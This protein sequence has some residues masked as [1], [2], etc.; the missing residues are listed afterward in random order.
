MV[1]ILLATYNSEPYIR[2]QL[3]SILNQSYKEWKLVVRDDLSN[4]RTVEIISEYISRY[5]DKISIL[6]NHGESKRAYLNFV[7]LLKNVES[8]YYMFCDHDDVWL[9][10]KI[11]LS[12]KRMKEVEKPDIPVVVHTD[13]RVVNEGLDTICDSF[14]RYSRL[15]P[16]HVEFKELAVCNSVNGCT[17]A[18]NKKARDLSLTHV[19]HA[20][21]HDKLV[22]RTVAANGGIISAIKAPTVLYR[23]HLDNVVGAHLRNKSFYKSKLKHLRHTIKRNIESWRLSS[24]IQY[25]SF[26][27]FIVMKIKMSYYRYRVKIRKNNI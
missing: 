10:Y 1:T 6:D 25:Y 23:Q 2:E 11:E 8:E 5:P 18:F 20:R 4:D 14:W 27:S 9:P 3:D 13:M 15:L 21:M 12:M 16:D 17:M 19:A 22:A 24:Q 26:A 7:E